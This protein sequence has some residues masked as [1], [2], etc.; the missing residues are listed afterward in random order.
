MQ[1]FPELE[2]A[3]NIIFQ[4][5]TK[6]TL[7]KFRNNVNPTPPRLAKSHWANSILK[8]QI[9]RNLREVAVSALKGMKPRKVNSEVSKRTGNSYQSLGKRHGVSSTY[10]HEVQRDVINDLLVNRTWE[11]K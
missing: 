1:V 3:S 4:P 10:S 2:E 11:G 9:S 6:K 7:K 8:D 5:P